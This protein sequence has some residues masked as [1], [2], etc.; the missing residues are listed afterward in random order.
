MKDFF[1]NNRKRIIG[2]GGILLL[3]A[4]FFQ[5]WPVPFLIASTAF[6]LVVL[7]FE[8]KLFGK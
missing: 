3:F 6:P 1:A 2:I 5:G 8:D 7:T 4:G